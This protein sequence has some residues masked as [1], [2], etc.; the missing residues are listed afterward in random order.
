MGGNL[1]FAYIKLAFSQWYYLTFVGSQIFY[2]CV[3]VTFLL[4]LIAFWKLTRYKREISA[5]TAKVQRAFI[6]V[7]DSESV[8]KLSFQLLTLEALSLCLGF[9]FDFA[10]NLLR[11]EV[12]KSETLRVIVTV[13]GSCVPSLIPTIQA[14]AMLGLVPFFREEIGSFF[15]RTK[16]FMIQP[17][18]S[19]S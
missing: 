10:R 11:D 2:V 4:G 5:Q 18:H 7:G 17:I 3:P 8:L 12:V 1:I 15:C 19:L 6:Y 16:T 14:V 13:Y 9:I